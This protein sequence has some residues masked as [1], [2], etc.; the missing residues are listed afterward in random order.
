MSDIESN[1]N[2]PVAEKVAESVLALDTV[3]ID[4]VPKAPRDITK[5]S[6]PIFV[7]MPQSFAK[8]IV[9]KAIASYA[10]PSGSWFRK[11]IRDVK[12]PQLH[13]DLNTVINHIVKKFVADDND[14]DFNTQKQQLMLQ[15]IGS[16]SEITETLWL[17]MTQTSI[18]ETKTVENKD[19]K[20]RTIIERS[21]IKPAL[22]HLGWELAD[23]GI[24]YSGENKFI[25]HLQKMDGRAAV[26]N[27][28][29]V[30]KIEA[31]N[32]STDDDGFTTVH[33]NT[34]TSKPD[35]SS[36]Y[37]TVPCKY[38]TETGSCKYGDKCTFLHGS[39]AKPFSKPC[40]FAERCKFKDTTCKFN[41]EPIE[42][43]DEAD[44]TVETVEKPKVTSYA[45]VTKPKP[46]LGITGKKI[47]AGAGKA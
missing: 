34:H 29:P 37:R 3:I 33:Y 28:T 41:H 22:E 14:E 26:Y 19:G 36:N 44:E 38:F 5:I 17:R 18:I 20:E 30:F 1:I 13:I 32:K 4:K 25:L 7:K 42:E 8:M 21:T 10:D 23:R 27:P 11:F 39:S 6:K 35:E 24:E 16:M 2:K 31:I 47:N 46:T 40:N 45:T 15:V 43:T 12:N 9:D